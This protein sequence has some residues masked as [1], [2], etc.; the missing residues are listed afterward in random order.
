MNLREQYKKRYQGRAIGEEF[1]ESNKKLRQK[2]IDKSVLSILGA[3]KGSMP[4]SQMGMPRQEEATLKGFGDI[5]RFGLETLVPSPQDPPIAAGFPRAFRIK[6]KFTPSKQ[7]P[8]TMMHEDP[9]IRATKGPVKEV[10]QQMKAIVSAQPQPVYEAGKSYTVLNL[11]LDKF[12]ELSQNAMNIG[13]YS[14]EIK[15]LK[16]ILPQFVRAFRGERLPN[17]IKHHLANFENVSLMPEPPNWF[18]TGNIQ[19][20][21]VAT[22]IV[23]SGLINKNDIIAIGDPLEL[24]VIVPAGKIMWKESQP[25]R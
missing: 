15:K 13:P 2:V 7:D 4:I 9:L 12:A 18:S 14:R 1:L 22:D 21:P 17:P 11:G 19:G 10:Q 6:G 25:L 20:K 23:R 5:M 3:L 24:E 16:D 8:T